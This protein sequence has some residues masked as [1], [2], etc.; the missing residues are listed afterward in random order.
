MAKKKNSR[1]RD[2]QVLGSLSTPKLNYREAKERENM[3]AGSLSSGPP[4]TD[5]YAIDDPV[6]LFKAS[7]NTGLAN[8]Q[9]MTDN[10]RAS[11]A[12]LMGNEVNMQNA[13]NDAQRAEAAGAWYLEGQES[14]EEFLDEPTFGG[15]INQAI[16][17]TGQ[18]VPSAVASIALA[19][20]GAGVGVG[21][22]A[23]VARGVGVKSITKAAS[24]KTLPTTISDASMTRTKVQ[25]IVNKYVGLEAAKAQ[26]KKTRMKPLNPKEQKVIDELYAHVRNRVK[27]KGAKTGAVLGAATQEQVMGQGIAF[28]NFAEQGMTGK[29][30]VFQSSLQGLGFAAIGV[31]SEVAV[32]RAV[33]NVIKTPKA[34]TL[35][36]LKDAPIRSR[37]SRFGEV[38]GVT[39]VSEGLAEG[40]Q[41]ELSIQQKFRIDE[42]YKR[43][44][45]NLDRANALFAGFFGGIG[46]GSAI[47]TPSA[48]VGKSYDQMQQGYAVAANEEYQKA[49]GVVLPEGE[50]QLRAQF[51]AMANPRINKDAVFVVD[52]DKANM[53]K[54]KPKLQKQKRF[55]TMFEVEISDVGTLYSTNEEVTQQF[56]NVMGKN[57]LNKDLL[58][59]ALAEIL[60]YS[61]RRAPG[62]TKAVRV[63]NPKGDV[64]WEQSVDAEGEADAVSRAEVIANKQ[65]GYTIDTIEREDVLSAREGAVEETTFDEGDTDANEQQGSFITEEEELADI[66]AQ[67]MKENQTMLTPVE[68]GRGSIT[69]PITPSGKQGWAAV[70]FR[71]DPNLVSEARQYLPAEF[72]AEFDRNVANGRYS[73]SLLQAFINENELE[74]SGMMFVKI[75]QAGPDSFNLVRHR[76]PGVGGMPVPPAAIQQAVQNAKDYGR[77]ARGR[78]VS[79]FTIQTADMEAPA[80]I[81][82]PSLTN[83]GR[84]LSQM[85]EGESLEGGKLGSALGGLAFML[86]QIGEG[87]QIFFDGK[88]FNEETAQDPG[89][90][91]YEIAERD[92]KGNLKGIQRFTLSDL[93]SGKVPTVEQDPKFADRETLIGQDFKENQEMVEAQIK[94]QK[95]KIEERQENPIKEFTTKEGTVVNQ[96]TVLAKMDEKLQ[97]LETE[98]ERL[99]GE[100]K[101]LGSDELTADERAGIEFQS[102][103][104]KDYSSQDQTKK[105]RPPRG[106][107]FSPSI[108]ADLDATFTQNFKNIAQESLGLTR[109]YK[110]FS[111]N[112]D[113]LNSII[114]DVEGD[115]ISLSKLIAGQQERITAGNIE[116]KGKPAGVNI[117]KENTGLPYDLIIVQT[118]NTDGSPLSSAL[119]GLMVHTIGHEI[120]HAF[121][122]QELENSLKNPKLRKALQDAFAK[123]QQNNDTGQYNTPNEEQN[124]KEWM[125]DQVSKYLVDESLKATDQSSSF[126]KRLATRIKDFVTKYA[127][128][129]KKRYTANPAFTDYVQ[130]LG[131]RNREAPLNYQAKA[132]VEEVVEKVGQEINKNNPKV[133][134]QIQKTVS[135][136]KRTGVLGQGAEAIN[137]IFNTSDDILR[138][139]GKPGRALAEIFRSLSQSE[140]KTGAFTSAQAISLAKMN[141]LVKILGLKPYT[142]L[143]AVKTLVP[144]LKA[145]EGITDEIQA[146]LYEAEDER[147]ATDKL[148]PKAKAVREWFTTHYKEQGLED[149]GIA[150]REN[151]FTRKFN[152]HELSGNQKVYDDTLN[153]MVSKGIDAT[154]AQSILDEIIAEPVKANMD[155]NEV[156]P[157]RFEMGLAKERSEVL[158]VLSTPELRAVGA[159]EEPWVAMQSYVDGTV[160][161]AELAKRGGPQRIESLIQEIRKEYGEEKAQL[162]ADTVASML[163]KHQAL[164]GIM[165]GVNQVG[166]LWNVTTLLTF[167]TFASFPDLAGPVLRS[168][169]FKELR[170][171]FSILTSNMNRAEAE[172]LAKDIGVIGIDAL[173][174][175]YVGAGELDYLSQDTKE[176]TNAFF[177]LIGLDQFTR[178]TRIFAAGMGKSFLLNNAKRAQAGDAKAQA[179]LRELNVTAE[180]ILNWA[181]GDI[182]AAENVNVK[183]ALARFVDE[184]IVRPNA[185]ERPNWADD[186]RYALVWQL[187]GFFYSYGKTVVGGNAREM[188]RRYAENGLRGAAVP[189]FMGAVTLLP[190]TMLGF[191]LRERFKMGLAWLLP[192]VS[193][194]DKNYRRSQQMDWG[195]YSTEI[196]DRSGV[197]GPFTMALPLFLEEKRYGDPFWVGPLGPTFGKGFDFL[198]GD[199]RVKDLTPFYSPL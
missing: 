34:N 146:I 39:S 15:F 197:L 142:Y 134:K 94:D 64:I 195:E 28:G 41:E 166:L 1:D 53:E 112:D 145:N 17:A 181:G 127:A 156:S 82:M 144:G 65:A 21:V 137:Q 183:L 79:R 150:F 131:T 121:V 38:V 88:P 40:A 190:L 193:P 58:D 3:L 72:I 8:T 157:G 32:A 149:L 29:D 14:F 31:G 147:I 83:S 125:S 118:T 4:P 107:T 99:R 87:S 129:A 81:D 33:G 90:F 164:N 42:D 115:L 114:P 198:Q 165:R 154:L 123:E 22:S 126:F 177:R 77:S 173:T 96:E 117:K 130:E 13:L 106:L 98:L 153:L 12:S 162:A 70:D 52:A 135:N 10:F 163:G 45:A 160:K 111:A 101:E 138:Q 124:F 104:F 199:L 59:G 184:S 75:N 51:N 74:E 24:K 44:M 188:Q 185:A 25:K 80:P 102:R 158:E 140:E 174:Q 63:K 11:I 43:S 132:Q 18:F 100:D 133:A 69:D 60:G 50:K 179:N 5:V 2:Q 46:V 109:E 48:V 67:G 187:K 30:A 91:V 119:K 73:E 37:R 35:N 136:I 95:T 105:G 71:A 61:R 128:L 20:T 171:N 54:L 89:A 178:F 7:V 110:V 151:F 23:G 148:S 189:L 86:S 78:V 113:I 141:E 192:G 155:I 122:N 56:A 76:I 49:T 55:G 47:G 182:T 168:K 6:Q 143:G 85:Y 62:D 170:Q 108:E 175:T 116:T 139:L 191:D 176:K 180:E 36:T 26:G 169:S 103:V 196:I 194:Q 84:K 92:D 152:V 9:A 93:Q 167:A 19:M 27:V 68:K 172:Q 186:P 120:G 16:S 66:Y 97:K 161:K 57:P 159:L